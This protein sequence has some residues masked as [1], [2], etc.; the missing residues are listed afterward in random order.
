MDDR[1][2]KDLD[3]TD[4]EDMPFDR[5]QLRPLVPRPAL[6]TRRT[7]PTEEL[8]LL[9]EA[10]DR[11]VDVATLRGLDA[12]GPIYLRHFHQDALTSD[13]E[14][15]IF[16]EEAV[17]GHG[18]VYPVALPTGHA[19]TVLY[20]GPFAHLPEAVLA[21]RHWAE[22]LGRPV[23]GPA[24]EILCLSPPWAEDPDDS[25]ALVILPLAAELD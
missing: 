14:I 25:E 5:F 6:A 10:L 4:D 20:R 8:S 24:F 22:G 1:Q 9:T 11:V 7:L 2:L 23:R 19:A 12:P 3:L 18:D 17:E 21:L 13:V 16:V 15:G